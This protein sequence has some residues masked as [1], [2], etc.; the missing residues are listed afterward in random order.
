MVESSPPSVKWVVGQVS[1]RYLA[2]TKPNPN[3]CTILLSPCSKY[4]LV[5]KVFECVYLINYYLVYGLSI[6]ILVY[7]LQC[8]LGTCLL[9]PLYG[10]ILGCLPFRNLGRSVTRLAGIF[11]KHRRKPVVQTS[12]FFDFA[13]ISF[14]H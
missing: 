3:H 8:F 5:A 1:N 11:I 2:S 12:A 9:I 14:F 10:C 7:C 13:I 6:F 4:R